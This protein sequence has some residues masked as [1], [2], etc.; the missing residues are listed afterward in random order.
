MIGLTLR[1]TAI[2]GAALALSLTN[3]ETIDPS[4]GCSRASIGTRINKNGI[5]EIVTTGPELVPNP[6]FDGVPDNTPVN[7][8]PGWTIAYG[9]PTVSAIIGNQLTITANA[10]NQGSRLDVAT[11]AGRIYRLKLDV[12]QESNVTNV[13]VVSGGSNFTFLP[14]KGANRVFT[15]TAASSATTVYFLPNN[16][17]GTGTCKLTNISIQQVSDA[18]RFDYDLSKKITENM[19]LNS[20]INAVVSSTARVDYDPASINPLGG[21]GCARLV[22]GAASTI[23]ESNAT[24]TLYAGVSYCLSV[25][26]KLEP[27]SIIK[28]LNCSVSSAFS[29]SINGGTVNLEALTNTGSSGFTADANGFF[30][31]WFVI[32]PTVTATGGLFF[33]AINALNSNNFQGDS[34]SGIK[35]FGMQLEKGVLPSA[36]STTTSTPVSAQFAPRGLLVESPSTNLFTYSDDLTNAA[37]AFYG[38]FSVTRDQLAPDGTTNA[39]KITSTLGSQVTTRGFVATDTKVTVSIYAKAG[40]WNPAIGLRN[41]T[42]STMLS[43]VTLLANGTYGSTGACKVELAQNGFYRISCSGTVAIGDSLSLY[44]GAQGSVPVGMYWYLW[45]AQWENAATSSSYIPTGATAVTRQTDVLTSKNINWFQ[46]PLGTFYVE[47]D[48][49][50]SVGSAIILTLA[51]NLGSSANCTPQF[52][53]LPDG[54]VRAYF[55]GSGTDSVPTTA[56]VTF[57]SKFKAAVS[58]DSTSISVSLNGTVVTAARTAIAAPTAFQIGCGGTSQALNGHLSQVKHYQRKMTNQELIQLTT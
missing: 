23:Q 32:L 21:T 30:R 10:I 54:R 17:A 42:T 2:S 12:T 13:Y 5:L 19:L 38:A 40:T 35:F 3:S 48:C 51:S 26:G 46:S 53:I 39:S 9:S 41:N 11:V 36:Y 29:P 43:S 49:S 25:Y 24:V 1:R 33:R 14:S 37:Y 57:G 18:P 44:L 56:K 58:F 31:C 34:V 55:S 22:C 6:S 7:S 8:L 47:G 4:F 15:F 45:G 20:D 52:D 50:T 16:N 27:G 28:G